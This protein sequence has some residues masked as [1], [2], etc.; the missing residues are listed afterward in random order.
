MARLVATAAEASL[1]V[2]A[3]AIAVVAVVQLAVVI[4]MAE[5]VN[6]FAK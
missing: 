3:A 4:P 2:E 6:A 5:G 1:V